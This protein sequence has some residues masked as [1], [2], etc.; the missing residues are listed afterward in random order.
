MPL[1]GHT[2]ALRGAS[3]GD[4]IC[5]SESF[6]RAVPMLPIRC[7]FGTARRVRCTGWRSIPC[8]VPCARPKGARSQCSRPNGLVRAPTRCVVRVLPRPGPYGPP[9]SG[10]DGAPRP[11]ANRPEST[12]HAAHHTVR[13]LPLRL[14]KPSSPGLWSG[15]PSHGAA[16]RFPWCPR[17]RCVPIRHGRA[18]LCR[19]CDKGFG[20]VGFCTGVK[21]P[22]TTS[23]PSKYAR[24]TRDA[25][26]ARRLL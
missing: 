10:H 3:E 15:R 11:G 8:S 22:L 2:G 6:A 21:S 26:V 4:A 17:I 20:N 19:V 18:S 13:R 9:Y 25:F 1:S 5:L 12:P 16:A 7:R 24:N 23:K 14:H